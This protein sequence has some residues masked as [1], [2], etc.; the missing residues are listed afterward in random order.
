MGVAQTLA[1]RA[2]LT[3]K[4]GKEKLGKTGKN[5]GRMHQ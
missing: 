1:L 5:W 2:A 3:E 4:S